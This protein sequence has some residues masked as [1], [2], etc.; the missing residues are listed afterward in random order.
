M[1]SKY[2]HRA[3]RFQIQTQVQYR[4][5]GE[6]DWYEGTT[7]NMSRSGVL[8][9]AANDLKPKTKL[10]MRILFP[11]EDPP[12]NV[13]CWGRIV[14]KEPPH[15][16]DPRPAVAAAILRYRFMRE[17]ILDTLGL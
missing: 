16:P 7:I 9:H 17:E 2:K 11:S 12:A 5:S 10:E 13:I 4:G 8:F 6:S 3:P 14:R 15:A 1:R